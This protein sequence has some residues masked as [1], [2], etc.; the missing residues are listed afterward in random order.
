MNRWL[1]CLLGGVLLGLTG[2]AAAAESSAVTG[3]KWDSKPT[4]AQIAAGKA[5]SMSCAGCH[6]AAGNSVSADFPNLSGLNYIYLYK[7]L[8]DFKRGARKSPIMAPM[9]LALSEQ[10]LRDLAAYYSEQKYS[11]ATGANED[12]AERQDKAGLLELG[13]R[14]YEQGVTAS[15]VTACIRCHG[16]GAAGRVGHF[17]RLAGQHAK[18]LAVQI[19]AFKAGRRSNDAGKMMEHVAL[20]MSEREIEAVAFYLQSLH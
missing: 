9:V 2:G 12:D 8:L 1:C 17:P 16:A 4:S 14:I 18:Y 6:G 15:G 7:Q 19:K 10:N 20:P 11:P 3:L 13:K 5:L